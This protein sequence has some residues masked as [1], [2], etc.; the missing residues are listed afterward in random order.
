VGHAVRVKYERLWER[1]IESLDNWTSATEGRSG[2]IEVELPNSGIPARRARIS[3]T[4]DEWAE[5]V[6]VMWGDFDSALQDVK[7]TLLTLQANEHFALYA[8]YRLEPSTEPTLPEPQI[9]PPG[10][11]EW[12]VLDGEGRVVSRY[13]DWLEPDEPR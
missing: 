1:L 10:T 11:G 2:Q 7:R 5:M 8:D 9:P 3:M 4:P 6:T 12:L 13:A